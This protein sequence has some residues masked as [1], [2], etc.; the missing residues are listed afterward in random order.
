MLKA[1]KLL[2]DT[3]WNSWNGCLPLPLFEDGVIQFYSGQQPTNLNNYASD[4]DTLLAIID[5][6]SWKQVDQNTLSL[7]RHG[8]TNIL[9]S[10]T[11]GW[12]KMVNSYRP[13]YNFS[14]SCGG[15]GADFNMATLAITP[16][17]TITIS[18]FRLYHTG[19]ITVRIQGMG[20]QMEI[21]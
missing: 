3:I 16:D 18:C 20:I 6:L 13:D 4:G 5:S 8:E 17:T 12:F 11:V 10:G 19:G 1:S 21:F 15:S 14:G 2:S 7:E 9:H